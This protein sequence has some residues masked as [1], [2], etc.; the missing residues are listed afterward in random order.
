MENKEQIKPVEGKEIPLS[1]I[2]IIRQIFNLPNQISDLE[3][4]KALYICKIYN[5]NPLKKEV[6]FVPYRRPDGT[7]SIQ[8]VISYTYYLKKAQKFIKSYE[9][10]TEKIDGDILCKVILYDKD[11]NQFEHE[12]LLS[13][14]KKD[15]PLWAKMPM[16]MLKKTAIVQAIRLRYGDIIFESE[17]AKALQ[18]EK[19]RKRMFLL[20]KKK[21]IVERD[22]RIKVISEIIQRNI[23]STKELT[24]EEI[25]KVIKALQQ[26]G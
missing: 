26:E 1:R 21:G 12:V 5:V 3:I 13:E 2:E 22:E 20:L 25:A 11:G 6:H 18:Y 7:Y 17:E 8:T 4:A 23:S 19:M 14:V 9:I 15:T 24:K 10:K 16:F